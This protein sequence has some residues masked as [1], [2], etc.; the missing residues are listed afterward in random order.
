MAWLLGEGRLVVADD[1]A[2]LK[3]LHPDP[4]LGHPERQALENLMRLY[5]SGARLDLM[6]PRQLATRGGE[7]ADG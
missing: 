1:R 2:T 6:T 5:G 4:P 7:P 3:I